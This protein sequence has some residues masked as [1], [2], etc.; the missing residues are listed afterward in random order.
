M[1]ELELLDA[2]AGALGC[3][4]P[5]AIRVNPDVDANTHPY[6]STGLRENKFGIPMSDAFAV[7]ERAAALPHLDITGVACHI[8]SQLT[9]IEP[10]VDAAGR[11]M[12]LVGDLATAGI[13]VGHVDVGG[14]LGIAYGTVSPPAIAD[15]V[16][17]ICRVV[18]PQYRIVIEPGRSIVGD[19]GLLLTQVLSVKETHVKTFAIC[20]ASMTELIRPALYQAHHPVCPVERGGALRRV[21]VVGPVCET[22]DFLAR[23]RDLPVAPGSFLAIMDCGAYGAVMASNYNGRPRP[24]E[25]VVDGPDVHLVRERERV[26]ALFEGENRLP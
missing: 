4:A 7:Y 14:G 17:A 13:D 3:R 18:P 26:D 6:I 24:A 10:I 15:Y 5:I 22:A 16:G 2:T 8:G 11:I 1:H 19:S 21:D 23:E 20:D 12:Q 9:S 25:V